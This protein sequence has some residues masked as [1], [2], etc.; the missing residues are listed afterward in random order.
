MI[1]RRFAWRMGR[2][3][4]TRA[5]GEGLNDIASNG[6]ALL[7][8]EFVAWSIRLS[9]RAVVFDV[10]ANV[11]QWT[12]SLIREA[13]RSHASGRIEI[14]AFEPEDAAFRIL[15]ECCERESGDLRVQRARCAMS[16]S[17]GEATLHV[18]GPAAGTNSLHPDM[19]SPSAN[20][21]SVPT[22]A[23]DSYCEGNGVPEVHFFKSDTE[24]HDFDVLLGAQGLFDNEG[25]G[26]FQF[27]YNH[28]WIYSRR[29]LKDVFEFANDRPYW[30]GKL[31][32]RGIEIIERWHPE[33]ERFFETNYVLV[34]KDVLSGYTHRFLSLD[35]SNTYA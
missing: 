30:I 2:A 29:Y 33:L 25:I 23:A 3:L 18:A 15:D 27:E 26:L 16:S 11:G 6:E 1:A 19:T 13:R 20:T 4:Y 9:G 17:D 5:R 34:H 14:H 28:R 12:L 10:G 32:R 8:R 21:A 35:A 31:T 22:C 7:Q 24:G